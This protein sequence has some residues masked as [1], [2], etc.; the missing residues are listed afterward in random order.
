[1]GVFYHSVLMKYLE[2]HNT[3]PAALE[4]SI[5]N[6]TSSFAGYSMATYVLGV[7]DRHSDNIQ[8]KKSGEVIYYVIE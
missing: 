2:E 5:E 8:L 7:R 4:Q 1:M 3:T 6:F